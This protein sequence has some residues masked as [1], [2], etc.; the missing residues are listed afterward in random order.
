M[1]SQ[2]SIIANTGVTIED[3]HPIII[4]G[5]GHSSISNVEAFS[6]GNGALTNFGNSWDYMTI[7]GNE[8]CTVSMF[9]CRMRD[10]KAAMPITILNPRAI[11]QVVGCLDKNE[12]PFLL[13]GETRKI[14]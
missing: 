5:K 13:P 14:P 9:G 10:Y 2:G 1:I 7:R 12:T 8:K 3:V 11:I 6:G 4:E